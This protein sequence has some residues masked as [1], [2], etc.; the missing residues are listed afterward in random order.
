ME[1]HFN[2]TKPMLGEF[3]TKLGFPGMPESTLTGI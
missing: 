2:K 3:F 1:T